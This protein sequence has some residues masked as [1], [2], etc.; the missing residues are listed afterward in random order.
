MVSR[1]EILLLLG[2]SL[3]LICLMPVTAVDE[4]IRIHFLLSPGTVYGP[5]D[6]GTSYH[7]R[8]LSNS[9]LKGKVIVE[10]EGVCF[11]I[12]GY[13]TP[14]LN[15]INIEEKYSF[16]INPA[17][18]LYTFTFDNTKGWNE[19]SVKFTLEETFSQPSAISTLSGLVTGLTGFIML[20]TGLVSLIVNRFKTRR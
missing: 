14:S 16:G 18:D 13:N 20:L 5:P 7:T 17:A 1:T 15:S 19:S 3:M 2:L 8:I 12:Q 11:S 4:V 10:G 6:P 9:V